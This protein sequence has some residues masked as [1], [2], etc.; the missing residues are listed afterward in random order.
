MSE[1]TVELKKKPGGEGYDPDGCGYIYGDVV[2]KDGTRLG[3][4]ILQ[5]LKVRRSQIGYMLIP[6]E[7]EEP[8]DDWI[9]YLDGEEIARIKTIEALEGDFVRKLIEKKGAAIIGTE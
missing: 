2:H 1:W 9:V 3:V 8:N 6:M 5:P 7:D 4:N